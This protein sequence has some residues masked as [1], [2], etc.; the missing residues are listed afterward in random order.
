MAED[1]KKVQV[2]IEG[3]DNTGKAFQS[4]KKN[5]LW[6]MFCFANVPTKF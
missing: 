6:D 3:K 1:I 4:A 2:N 5:A